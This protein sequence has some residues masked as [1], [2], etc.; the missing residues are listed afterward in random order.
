MWIKIPSLVTLLLLSLLSTSQAATLELNGAAAYSQ[1]TREYYL[2][3]L[4][5]PKRSDDINYILADTTA[6]RMQIVIRIPSWSP[7]RWSQI[8]QNNIAINNDDLSPSPQLQQALIDFTNFP[9]QDLQQGDELN[10]EYQPNGNSRVLLNGDVVLEL[11]GTEFFNYMV[12]TWI[13]KLPPTREFRQQIL[14]QEE[15]SA[16]IKAT[17]L[18]HQPSRAG[19]FAG[20]IAAERATKVAAQAAAKA[21][22]QAAA[23]AEEEREQAR[24][25][26]AQASA[27]NKDEQQA[28]E[29][30]QA[31]LAAEK[32]A[33]ERAASQQ[34]QQ[35][36]AIK[37]Q[38]ER[39]AREGSQ[40]AAKNLAEEQRYYLNMLQWQLQRQTDAAVSYPGWAKQFNQEGLVELDLRINRKQEVSQVQVRDDSVPNLLINEVQRAV[41]VAAGKLNIADELAGDSWPVT[42]RYRFSLKGQSLPENAMPKVPASLQKQASGNSKQ[43]EQQY[44]SEQ[45]QRVFSLV[46]YPASARLLK[47]QDKVQFSVRLASDGKVISVQEVQASRHRELNQAM[48]AAI[49]AAEPFPPLPT[50]V[51]ELILVLDYEFKL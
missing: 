19:L 37:A 45:G 48:Q 28:S 41:G 38:A 1:L 6:K 13:G 5:L 8:W 7:R 11:S 49:N 4:Y 9:R 34:K 29:D 31:R 25:R 32:L 42:V 17:V 12:K 15:I 33:K 40:T 46:Q 24:L 44:R 10:I 23:R 50:G 21:A 27:Q 43:Q 3:A 51:K 26:S 2:G 30:R 35:E 36:Q 47:K 16:Q 18:G 22:E 14:G 39:L 20:W